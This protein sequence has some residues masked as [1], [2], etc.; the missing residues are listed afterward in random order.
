MGRHTCLNPLLGRQAIVLR[1]ADTQLHPRLGPGKAVRLIDGAWRDTLCT[2]LARLAQPIAFFPSC[3]SQPFTGGFVAVGAA[4]GADPQAES[5]RIGEAQ[6][7]A[8]LVVVGQ[9]P[10]AALEGGGYP[11]ADIVCSGMDRL[12]RAPQHHCF[13]DVVDA[14]R[15]PAVDRDLAEAF[16]DRQQVDVRVVRHWNDHPVPIAKDRL[17]LTE[18]MTRAAIWVARLAAIY[19][20]GEG[21]VHGVPSKVRGRPRRLL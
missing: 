6:A 3:L 11:L 15:L 21:A 8:E 17:D 9:D 19:G 7:G 5:V 14:C 4:D 10:T 13:R 2:A 12:C 16:R 20:V 1:S 18:P